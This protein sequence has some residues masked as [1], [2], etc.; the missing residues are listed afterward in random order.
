[1]DGS[2]PETREP[3]EATR[4]TVVKGLATAAGAAAVVSTGIHLRP[5][6]DPNPIQIPP[7]EQP[8]NLDFSLYIDS[9]PLLVNLP[10][11]KKQIVE[12]WTTEQINHYKRR[13]FFLF[14]DV[15]DR[16]NRSA[17]WVEL[18]NQ[19][20]DNLGFRSNSYVR[21]VLTYLIFVESGGNEN[22]GKDKIDKNA[23]RGLCQVR[24]FSVEPIAKELGIKLDPSETALLNPDINI[25]LALEYL[26]RLNTIFP[27]PTIAVWAYHLGELNMGRAIHA[28]VEDTLG[29]TEADKQTIEAKFKDL[30]S[31]ATSYYIKS[32]NL[33]FVDLLT[34]KAVVNQLKKDKAFGDD[35]EY[36]VS[37]IIAAGYLMRSPLPSLVQ[38]RD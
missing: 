38:T 31:P 2:S 30:K 34:S 26:H 27:D 29:K 11:D 5:S 18:V 4:R 15:Q 13:S 21:D 17:S 10:T 6:S 23:A 32:L 25:T 16:V 20:A 14:R 19:K 37:R 28:Y 12:T 7:A 33:N 36:Y 22:A 1:M 35:T 8:D 9:H 24:L 3:K